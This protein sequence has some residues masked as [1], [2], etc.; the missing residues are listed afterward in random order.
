M[1]VNFLTKNA[2]VEG[3]QLNGLIVPSL[4]G[5][6]PHN[7]EALALGHLGL[8]IGVKTMYIILFMALVTNKTRCTN[9]TSSMLCSPRVHCNCLVRDCPY[10]S[11]LF[12]SSFWVLEIFPIKLTCNAMFGMPLVLG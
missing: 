10:E 3:K 1:E 5:E 6:L 12:L 2:L 11:T 7:G 9:R 4:L 8:R